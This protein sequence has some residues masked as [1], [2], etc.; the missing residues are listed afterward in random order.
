MGS[1]IAT[2]SRSVVRE[3]GTDAVAKVPLASTPEGW[4]RYEASFTDAVWRCGAPVPK[5]LDLLVIEGRE[6]SIF[7]RVRGPSMW[8]AVV[9]EPSTAVVAGRELAELHALVLSIRPPLAV[10]DQATRLACKI[11]AAVRAGRESAVEFL[12]QIP[13]LVRPRALCHGDFHPKNVMLGPN[14]PIVVDWFDVSSGEAAAD[15]ARTMLLLSGDGAVDGT[16]ERSPSHLPGASAEVLRT[17]ADSYRGSIALLVEFSDV[18]L[19]RWRSVQM[20]ARQSEEMSI[21]A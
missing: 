2:G 15:I 17:V 11:R 13:P 5:V 4:V 7:E 1:T 9:A 18:E 19:E 16:D 21:V 20:V 8:D 3:W 6:V 12:E 14:G 10:P